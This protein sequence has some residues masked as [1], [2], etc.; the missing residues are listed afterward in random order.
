MLMRHPVRA[1]VRRNGLLRFVIGLA[2]FAVC[3]AIAVFVVPYFGH[4]LTPHGLIPLALPGVFA[5]S[6]LIEFVTGISFLEFARRWD[7]LK[8]WRRGVFGSFIVLVAGFLIIGGVAL[9]LPL[10][11]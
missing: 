7:D 10:F 11:L 1:S 8:G 9:V 6:G 4:E 2:A 3:L 5:L